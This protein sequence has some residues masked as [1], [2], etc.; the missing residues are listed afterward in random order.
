M[1]VCDYSIKILR[2]IIGLFLISASVKHIYT[3]ISVVVYVCIKK[4][5]LYICV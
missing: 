4:M 3:Y 1:C 5:H 2:F